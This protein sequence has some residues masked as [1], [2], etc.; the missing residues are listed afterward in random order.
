MSTKRFL[1]KSLLHS[2]CL[3]LGVLF[4]SGCTTFNLTPRKS[5]DT[6]DIASLERAGYP[7]DENGAILPVQIK[8]GAT[9]VILEVHN[10][11]THHEMIPM[12]PDKPLF[13]EDVVKDAKLVERIGKIKVSIIRSTTPNAPP[14]RMDVGFDSKGKNVMQE[15]NYALQPNDRIIIRKN[16][17][18]W[19]DQALESV[20]A[21][22]NKMGG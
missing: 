6:L 8:D 19:I 3:G 11:E 15:Q 20:T 12:R 17:R 21:H 10:G 2:L 14:V 13:V 7:T 1:E 5:T 9:G 4:A 22:R 18:S 16:D